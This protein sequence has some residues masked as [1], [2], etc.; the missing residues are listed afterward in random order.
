[1]V[2]SAYRLAETSKRIPGTY[3]RVCLNSMKLV[4][5][6]AVMYLFCDI[7]AGLDLWGTVE[8]GGGAS[9]LLLAGWNSE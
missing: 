5:N 3:T 7:A 1:M 6:W 9:F 2:G 4:L 8:V